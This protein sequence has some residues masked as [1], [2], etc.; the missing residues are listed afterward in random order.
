[1]RN[2]KVAS[3]WTAWL[4]VTSCWAILSGPGA[5]FAGGEAMTLR[6]NDA[7]TRP[8]ARVAVVLRTYAPRGISQGQVCFRSSAARP[9]GEAPAGPFR[10][11]DEVVVFSQTGDAEVVQTFDGVTQTALIEFQSASATINWADGPLAVLFF[12]L[13]PLVAPGDEFDLILDLANSFLFDA[14][15]QVI[16]IEPRAGLLTVLAQGVPSELSA[17]GDSVP[18]GSVAAL[19]VETSELF[20][21]GSG[22]VALSYDPDFVSGT[23]AVTMDPRHGAAFF[24][25]DDLTPG[26]VV[27]SFSSPDGSLNSVPGALVSIAL[28]TSAG[29]P[30]GS[31]SGVT[32]DPTL[33]HLEDPAGSPIALTLA[34]DVLEV[35]NP[36]SLIFSDGFESGDLLR[37]TSVP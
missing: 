20:A 32:L 19:G 17:E 12:H 23:P 15:G 36:A 10:S 14:E 9:Q 16:P 35:G 24:S 2:I 28:P 31:Q 37:W 13:T 1:M 30:P 21:V 5:L 26:R 27:V 6:I 7:T 11:L 29:L 22:R 18:A 8:G 25:V 34:G 4:A 33:T 3:R